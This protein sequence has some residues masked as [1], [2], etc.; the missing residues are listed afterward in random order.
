ME[1]KRPASL[2]SRL[3][4]TV[5]CLFCEQS[6]YT[7]NPIKIRRILFQMF[8]ANRNMKDKKTVLFLGASITQGMI[9]SSYVK[10]LKRRLGKKQYRFVNHGVAG[11]ESYNVMRKL[12]KGINLS[13]DYVIMLVGT[14][15]VLS[16]LDPKLAELTRKLKKIPHEPSII[17][18]CNNVTSILQQLK[19]DSGA[20]V[21][22]ASLP[23]VGENLDSIENRTIAEYNTELKNIAG[24]ENVDYLPIFER[25]K[26]FLEQ[27]LG[28]KGKDYINSQKLAYSSLLCHYL[29]FM[30]FDRISRNNGY[31]LLT[32]G[33]HQNS[34]G[35][36]YIADEIE[37]FIRS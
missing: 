30:S 17:H 24:N 25:Q 22:I 33:I 20:K 32:D 7:F 21:A 9:S 3:I 2:R 34:L 5:I 37:G 10:L 19:K 26:K 1:Q 14:N 31:L 18:Y 23:V 11:Y 35:A 4:S 16:S 36:K 29:L 12:G 6:I 27:K 28:G 13:P 8:E 15:D